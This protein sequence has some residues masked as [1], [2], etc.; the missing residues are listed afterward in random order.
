MAIILN[1]MHILTDGVLE[2]GTFGEPRA[3]E[4]M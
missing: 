2:G 1:S 3:V 4:A